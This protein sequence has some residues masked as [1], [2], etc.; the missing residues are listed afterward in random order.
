MKWFRFYS[1]VLHDPKVRRLSDRRFRQWVNLLCI[2]NASEPRGVLPPLS[3]L[4]DLL[5]LPLAKAQAVLDD[6][7]ERGFLDA[8]EGG[9]MPHNWPERQRT[10]TRLPL[11]VWRAIRRRVLRRDGFTC[12]YCGA[13]ER[14]EVDHVVP[15]VRG[16]SHSLSSLKTACLPCNRSKGSLLLEEWDGL[17]Q[18]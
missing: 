4:A 13:K 11:T 2:A 7:S 16:G 6:L 1:E 12:Q 18:A 10:V 14:L 15:F 8:T 9:L 5:R 3:D 17:G